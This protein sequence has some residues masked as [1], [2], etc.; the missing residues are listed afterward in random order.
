MQ[1]LV[2]IQ[3][4]KENKENPQILSIIRELAYEIC[5]KQ[6]KEATETNA[7]EN[8]EFM[9]GVLLQE[10]LLNA[11]STINLI[12]G[13]SEAVSENQEQYIYK[14][15]YEK[16]QIEKQILAQ[17]RIIRQNLQNTLEEIEKFIQNSQ[18]DEKE[19]MIAKIDEKMLCDLQMLGIL[20]ETTEAAFL[21]A[22]E[23]QEDIRDTIC[24]I[25]K[26]LV[27]NA[28][29]EDKIDK[30]RFLEVAQIV[31]ETAINIANVEH[32]FAGWII[33]G[34]LSG[35]RDGLI[36]AV[37]KFIDDI[38][39]APDSQNLL[40]KSQEFIKMED[41][42]VAMV[43]N[44]MANADEPAAGIIN[45]IL[46]SSLDSYFAKFKRMQ[47]EISAQISIRLE[48]LT[49]KNNI[50]EKI[51]EIKREI[52]QKS[53]KIRE[54]I[55]SNEK[56]ESIKKELNEIEKKLENLNYQEF[57][58]N[59]KNKAKELGEKMYKKAQTLIDRNKK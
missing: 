55:S 22:L 1:N 28:I 36:K 57:G 37:E 15:I 27:F 21:T 7:T 33:V 41:G 30:T 8:F 54:S 32:R 14:L 5:K 13:I 43:K 35:T 10:G 53:Y 16:E 50:A 34:A 51:D 20:K 40:E 11:K 49:N 48:E 31:C 59:V 29:N 4:I 23:H 26:N 39:F 6:I 56:F 12:Q 2:F 58:E 42:F 9:S 45:S 3:T 46:Q 19:Q 17:K 24:Q 38:K 44:L 18:F 47:H 25:A 52:S